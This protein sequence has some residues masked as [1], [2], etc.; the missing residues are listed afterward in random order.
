MTWLQ[1]GLN[2]HRL[3]NFPLNSDAKAA[4]LPWARTAVVDLE[5]PSH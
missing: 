2:L 3:N 5:L 1:N 4:R